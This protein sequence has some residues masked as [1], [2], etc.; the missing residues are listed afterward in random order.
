MILWVFGHLHMLNSLLLSPWFALLKSFHTAHQNWLLRS[1]QL[2]VKTDSVNWGTQDRPVEFK[3]HCLNPSV[4]FAFK[5]TNQK[6]GHGSDWS[7]SLFCN[8]YGFCVTNV[9]NPSFPES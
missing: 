7:I 3:E 1:R 5:K 2:P 9:T 6:K 4:Y 8:F